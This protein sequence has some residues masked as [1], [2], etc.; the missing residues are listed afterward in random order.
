MVNKKLVLNVSG[1][2]DS[3]VLLYLALSQGYEVEAI[4]FDYNQRHKREIEC[5]KKQIKNAQRKFKCKIKHS[6]ID[7]KFLSKISPT[8]SLTNKKIKTPD[9]RTIRGEAQPKS[10]V[11][12]RNMLFLSIAAAKAESIGAQVIWHGA[13]LVDSLAGYYDGS[14][15]WVDKVNELLAYNRNH[16]ITVEA[17]LIALSKADIIKLGVNLGVNF[18]DTYT[19][20]TGNSL[21]DA[22]SASSSLRIQGFIEAGYIDPIK[23]KQQKKL[24]SIYKENG[25]EK[26]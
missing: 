25:C 10:Y 26:I 12:N 14:V 5:A 20:Y 23:Y 17:P 21:A 11:P 4:T 16:R 2:A 3:A 13:A 15:E 24:D 9:V 6:T 8:S 7:V 1:G 19:C 22:N 18:A